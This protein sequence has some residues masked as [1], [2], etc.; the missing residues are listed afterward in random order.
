MR[1]EILGPLRVVEGEDVRTLS[2]R[3]TEIL[4]AALLLRANQVVSIDQLIAEIWGETPPRRAT[5][6]LHVY[7]SQLRKFLKRPGQSRSPIV[8]R[9][10]GYQFELDPDDLDLERFTALVERGR[11]RA[12]AHDHERAV[13]DFKAALGLW[14]GGLP[15]GPKVGGSILLGFLTWIEEVRL[16]TIEM[17][18]DSSLALGRHRTLIGQLFSLTAEYPM[19]EAFHRQLMLALYRSERQADALDVYRAARGILN[20]QLGLEPCRALQE[21]HQSI[22]LADRE[23]ELRAA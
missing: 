7:I 2:A 14:R 3:K 15:L 17:V 18:I 6:A 12:R 22:L 20:E 11:S 21:M 8:T 13:V 16:E 19:R 10:P 9:A 1:Y 4:L 5:A 23:L